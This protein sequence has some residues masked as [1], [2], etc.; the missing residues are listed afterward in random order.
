ME[1]KNSF[2]QPKSI[3]FSHITLKN[4]NL[5]AVV[6]NDTTTL[7]S[8]QFELA[9]IEAATNS[10]AKENMIGK[11]G[12]GEVYKVSILTSTKLKR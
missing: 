2:L 7:E 6:G 11:G 9:K 3:S 5:L 12:F 10:F 1:K 4:S 8:L